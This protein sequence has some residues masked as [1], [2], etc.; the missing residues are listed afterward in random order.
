M[1]KPVSNFLIKL[2]GLRLEL[3]NI[4]DSMNDV[5]ASKSELI[6]TLA[7]LDAVMKSLTSIVKSLPLHSGNRKLPRPLD[8][9]EAGRS[10]SSVYSTA[11]R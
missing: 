11:N 9:D 8:D 4:S 1:E 3:K 5:D 2:G 10:V 6:E 7:Q